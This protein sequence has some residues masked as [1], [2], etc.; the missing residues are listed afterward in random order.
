MA[1]SLLPE[2]KF[3]SMRPSALCSAKMPYSPLPTYVPPLTAKSRPFSINTP[4]PE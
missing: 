1:V 4:L 3:P 2:T